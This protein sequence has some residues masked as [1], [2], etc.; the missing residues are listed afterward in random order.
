MGTGIWSFGLATLV[1]L[2]G[3]WG[4]ANPP[5]ALPPASVVDKL[6]RLHNSILQ[7]FELTQPKII[8]KRT[9]KG[10]IVEVTRGKVGASRMEPFVPGHP[11]I[12]AESKNAKALADAQTALQGWREWVFLA[13]NKTS[14]LDV[15]HIKIT[16]G[17]GWGAILG[18]IDYPENDDA[19]ALAREALRRQDGKL[20]RPQGKWYW[21]ARVVKIG[22]GRCLNCH[23]K[24]KVGDPVGVL[25]YALHPDPKQTADG[26]DAEPN[27]ERPK[28]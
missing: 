26:K 13:G 24:S 18:K 5:K 28:R 1:G 17:K 21:E 11:F 20:V 27:A 25:V 19:L 2:S 4:L 10:E 12:T 16:H 22:D 9:L 8:R 7:D 6:F 23:T 14:P 15:E 3:A